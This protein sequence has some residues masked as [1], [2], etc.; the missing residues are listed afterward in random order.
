MDFQSKINI[1]ENNEYFFKYTLKNEQIEL[2]NLINEY[3]K[4]RI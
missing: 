1:L 3:R 2:I 4:K